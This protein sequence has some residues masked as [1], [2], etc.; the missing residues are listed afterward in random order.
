MVSKFDEDVVF[1]AYHVD[2]DTN[3]SPQHE[4]ITKPHLTISESPHYLDSAIGDSVSPQIQEYSP[5]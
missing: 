5:L 2:Q 4:T 1:E 3:S